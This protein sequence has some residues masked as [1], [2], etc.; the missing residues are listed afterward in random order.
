MTYE[1][2]DH[3]YKGLIFA[4]LNFTPPPVTL[5]EIDEWVKSAR[6]LEEETFNLTK[7]GYHEYNIHEELP[8]RKQ[9]IIYRRGKL[10][11]SF[12]E[13]FPDFQDWLDS[14]PTS[15]PHNFMAI[16]LLQQNDLDF[17][18]SNNKNISSAIHHDYIGKYSR[19]GYR[20]FLNNQKNHLWFYGC[21]KPLEELDYINDFEHLGENQIRMLHHKNHQFEFDQ[22]GMPIPNEHFYPKPIQ[23]RTIKNTHWIIGQEYACH[24]VVHEQTDENKNTFLFFYEDEPDWTRLDQMIQEALLTRKDEFIWLQDVI[25]LNTP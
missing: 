23:A 2:F 10:N 15:Y 9:I 24:Y 21:K 17:L 25:D 14:L 19:Y 8:L 11:K 20:Y 5:E 1:E 22:D 7:E 18:V 3:K 12:A 16:M 13:K 6:T 4:P